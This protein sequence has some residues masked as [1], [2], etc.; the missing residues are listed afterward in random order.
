MNNTLN[1]MNML[2]SGLL[3]SIIAFGLSAII[4]IFFRKRVKKPS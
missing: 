4:N 2:F 1:H 3:S